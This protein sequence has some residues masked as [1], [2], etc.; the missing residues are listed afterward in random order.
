M[1]DRKD[2]LNN[3]SQWTLENNGSFSAGGFF[4]KNVHL[5][6]QD[7][8]EVREAILEKVKQNPNE[9]R[10]E[11]INVSY[12]DGPYPYGA[13]M[14]RFYWDI[15]L[16]HQSAKIK[17][18]NDRVKKEEKMLS[19]V[20]YGKM[21]YQRGFAGKEW[22][23]IENILNK[24]PNNNPLEEWLAENKNNDNQKGGENKMFTYFLGTIFVI[25]L[26][27]GIFWLIRKYFF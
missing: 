1:T 16:I 25:I 9:W 22:K 19:K 4:G 23:E 20:D 15:F 2:I 21:H 8:K 11:K 10:I 3:L 14:R 27:L 13:E 5:S 7:E 24:N 6:S 17:L 26:F 18:I 12:V